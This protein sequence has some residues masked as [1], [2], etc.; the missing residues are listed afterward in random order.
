MQLW[1]DPISTNPALNS[2]EEWSLWN[3][4]ADAHPIHLHLVK[5]EVVNRE[6]IEWC[7]APPEPWENGWKDTVIVYPR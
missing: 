3:R 7:G 6:D 1:D 4:S 5:F 2:V